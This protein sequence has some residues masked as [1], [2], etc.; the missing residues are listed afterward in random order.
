MIKRFSSI[1]VFLFIII[2]PACADELNIDSLFRRLTSIVDDKDYYVNRK[3]GRIKNLKELL[4]TSQLRDNQKYEINGKLYQEYKKYNLDTALHYLE[5][6]KEIATQIQN[7]ALLDETTLQIVDI[8]SSKSLFVESYNILNQLNPKYLSADLLEEYYRVYGYFTDRY[9][10]NNEEYKYYEKS[11]LYRD[12]L[13]SV[14]KDI[15]SMKYQILLAQDMFY[16]DQS[17]P[18]K[19]ILLTL[20]QSTTDNDPERAAIS[21]W[22]SVI[23]DREKSFDMEEKYLIISAICDITNA[24]K[25]NASLQRLAILYS[26]RGDIDKA[27]KFIT[28]AMD[29][30][31]QCNVKYRASEA[32]KSYP[33]INAAYQD[34]EARQK[35]ELRIYLIFISIL[36]IILG[37]AMFYIYAQM[38]RVS[39][40]R[41]ELYHSSVKLIELNQDIKESNKK[42]HDT[43]IQLIEANHVKEEYIV[44]F[45]NMCSE[46]IHK[47]DEYRKSLNKLATKN[48]MA[49]LCIKLKSTT[50]VD[51]E[52]QEFYK[53]FDNI[54]LNLF[55]TFVSEFNALLIEEEQ[56][57]L[58][59]SELLNPELRIFALIRL[60]I[61]DSVKIASFLRYS[62]NTIYNYR[63]KIRNK[64]AVSRDSF[65]KMVMKI[66][67]IDDQN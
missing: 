59:N 2:P 36:A 49:E 10:Q 65:E 9:G 51:S 14:T 44:H 31:V 54:F 27:Y 64:A 21:Y 17:E 56:F 13:L 50:M 19:E 34:K 30:A 67:V 61:T 39:R 43:N 58:K 46:Y 5:K 41:K 42:L 24:I 12:S 20:L 3:E 7:K 66:G 16:K 52:L 48:A 62:L 4:K 11:D 63:T 25:D 1:V 8:Y 55:P 22:L 18:A 38:K 57:K 15:L 29:D 53:R 6:N 45:F 37:G 28:L 47:L 32:M 60:G 26:E 33:I 35:K 40:I 23:Y